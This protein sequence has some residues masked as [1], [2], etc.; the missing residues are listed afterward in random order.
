MEN[1]NCQYLFEKK[2]KKYP[3]GVDQSPLGRT[4]SYIRP[5]RREAVQRPLGTVIKLRWVRASAVPLRKLP[6]L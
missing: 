6:L 5:N 3:N 1:R 4:S 2:I